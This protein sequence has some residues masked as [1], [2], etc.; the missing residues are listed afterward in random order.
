MKQLPI[1]MSAEMVRALLREIAEAGTGKTETRRLATRW[2]EFG[3]ATKQFWEHGDFSRAWKDGVGSDLQ[4]LQVPCHIDAEDLAA[5]P[6]NGVSCRP[7]CDVCIDR[8][9]GTTHR[10]WPKIG[11][12]DRLWVR[13]TWR[14][15]IHLDG[16]KPVHLPRDVAIFREADGVAPDGF[17]RLRASFHMCRQDSRL[18]L[19]VERVK[20]EWLQEITEAECIAEG[21]FDYAGWPAT[22]KHL[23]MRPGSSTLE[24]YATTEPYDR[25]WGYARLWDHLHGPR[26]WDSN[27]LV[28]AIRFK[29]H[30]INVDRLPIAEAPCT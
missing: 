21:S 24:R 26:A 20:I 10:L 28:V 18:T 30:L 29:P 5:P 8:W 9:E 3:S 2:A 13:E 11:V 7:I 4:Y 16:A 25:R 23:G 27:P 17:G 6:H 12:G 1:I 22:E 14:A 15:P 19:V